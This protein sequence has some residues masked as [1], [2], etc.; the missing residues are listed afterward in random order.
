M[1]RRT[2]DKLIAHYIELGYGDGV[3]SEVARVSKAH[4]A[5]TRKQ[6]EELHGAT[7]VAHCPPDADTRTAP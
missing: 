7:R 4:V 5:N 3:I 1:R 6:Y 2:V